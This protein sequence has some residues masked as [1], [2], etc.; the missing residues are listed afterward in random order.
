[1]KGSEPK[2][3]S[4]NFMQKSDADVVGIQRHYSLPVSTGYFRTNLRMG[5]LG[6]GTKEVLCQKLFGNKRPKFLVTQWFL[7]QDS[8]KTHSSLK[9]IGGKRV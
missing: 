4:Q 6:K 7:L 2:E 1:M 5:V 9:N 8:V 3:F